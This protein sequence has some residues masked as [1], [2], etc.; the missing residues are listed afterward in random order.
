MFISLIKR[1]S[2]ADECKKHP[3]TPDCETPVHDN[4]ATIAVSVCVPVVVI[5]M[6]LGFF[7]WRNYRKD[8]KEMSEHDP[9]F[10]ETGDVTA[11]PDYKGYGVPEYA[12][13]YAGQGP[14]PFDHGSHSSGEMEKPA[15]MYHHPQHNQ[16][17]GSVT[18]SDPLQSF[19]PMADATESKLSLNDYLRQFP[20]GGRQSYMASKPRL[21]STLSHLSGA[22]HSRQVSESLATPAAADQVSSQGEMV[23]SASQGT[24]LSSG[25]RLSD[26]RKELSPFDDKLQQPP[27]LG[28]PAEYTDDDDDDDDVSHFTFESGSSTPRRQNSRRPDDDSRLDEFASREMSQK[29]IDNMHRAVSVSSHL[30]HASAAAEQSGLAAEPRDELPRP[31]KSPRISSFNLLANDSD[32]EQE[33]TH[34][35]EEEIQ[36]MKSV[37]RVYFD[38]GKD[39]TSPEPPLPALGLDKRMTTASSVYPAGDSPQAAQTAQ[40]GQHQEF[41][42]SNQFNGQNQFDGQNAQFGQHQFDG[43]FDSQFDGQFDSQHQQFD[44]YPDPQVAA[45]NGQPVEY[46]PNGYEL[47][48]PAFEGHPQF[49]PQPIPTASD[50][51]SSTLQTYTDFGQVPRSKRAQGPVAVAN[52]EMQQPWADTD[53]GPVLSATQMARNSVAMINPTGIAR[54]PTYKPASKHQI[55]SPVVNHDEGGDLVPSAG[56]DVRAMM[57]SNF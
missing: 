29:S 7:L 8:K 2:D 39:P 10:D 43:Q 17:A 32:E 47:S 48:S 52:P 11:L 23:H 41:N 53:N 1:A 9:D 31:R 4:A 18:T 27:T 12:K 36:R 19:L 44:G 30:R 28:A 14:N 45:Y 35:Q 42:E 24:Q 56:A 21:S 22:Q 25:S 16:S 49:T 20:D 46:S 26:A 57:N 5:C 13:A 38:K 50:I 55:G 40:F 37:Y 6:V 54:K 3:N 51:R 15:A 34:E 33:L